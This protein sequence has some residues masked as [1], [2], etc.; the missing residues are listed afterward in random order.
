MPVPVFKHTLHMSAWVQHVLWHTAQGSRASCLAGAGLLH[1]FTRVR[2]QHLHVA[3]GQCQALQ[4]VL[5]C[6]FVPVEGIC[7]QLCNHVGS[8]GF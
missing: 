3:A 2:D 1:V 7:H 6:L 8:Q 5:S 4:H